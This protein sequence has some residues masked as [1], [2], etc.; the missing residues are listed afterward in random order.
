[1][2]NR[3]Y[4]LTSVDTSHLVK[5]KRIGKCLVWVALELQR[6]LK[7]QGQYSKKIKSRVSCPNKAKSNLVGR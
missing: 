6:S 1:M 7:I 3:N 4:D 5:E 2:T